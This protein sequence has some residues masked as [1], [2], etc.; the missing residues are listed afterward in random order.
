MEWLEKNSETEKITAASEARAK[1]LNE[2]KKASLPVANRE[3][4]SGMKPFR[5]IKFQPVKSPGIYEAE[6]GVKGDDLIFH[7]WPFGYHIADAQNKATPRF[8]PGFLDKLTK[9]MHLTFNAK[10]VEIQD[11]KD[12]GAL[13]VCA[14]SWGANQF[15][16]ELAV[17]ACELLHVSMGG[18]KG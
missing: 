14:H 18:E 3:A 13:F 1:I 16:R 8:A 12:M 7:F 15:H 17:K 6:F 5:E 4:E 11:D 10:Q 9:V 2:E